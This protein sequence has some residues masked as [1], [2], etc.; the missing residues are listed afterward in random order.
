LST[1]QPNA[2]SKAAK[3]DLDAPF[4]DEGAQDWHLLITPGHV[5][6]HRTLEVGK[7]LFPIAAAATL[8]GL[9]LVGSAI[10]SGTTGQGGAPASVVRALTASPATASIPGWQ[11]PGIYRL[12]WLADAAAQ[13]EQG[14]SAQ[15]W[16]R[17]VSAASRDLRAHG[18]DADAYTD[19]TALDPAPTITR[20]ERVFSDHRGDLKTGIVAL[21]KGNPNTSA[22][23]TAWVAGKLHM[24]AV[25]AT[26]GQTGCRDILSKGDFGCGLPQ[27]GDYELLKPNK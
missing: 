2:R 4:P 13:P 21:P 23:I 10:Y 26:G 19:L 12:G 3:P 8:A 22:V 24:I 1:V 18:E 6:G 5:C 16:D 7:R 15:Q 20:P 9:W 27:P 11:E 25:R 17:L 14:L